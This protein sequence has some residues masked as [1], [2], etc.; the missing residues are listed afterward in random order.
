MD[1]LD[2]ARMLAKLLLDLVPEAKEGDKI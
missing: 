2:R 1:P